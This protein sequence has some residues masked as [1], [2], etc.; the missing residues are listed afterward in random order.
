MLFRSLLALSTSTV[1]TSSI[2]LLLAIGVRP[3]AVQLVP[4]VVQDQHRVELVGRDIVQADVYTEVE[5]RA[6]VQSA[7]D[8]QSGFTGLRGV[9]FVL[10]AVVAT[11]TLRRVRTEAGIAQFLAPKGPMDEVAKGGLLRPLPR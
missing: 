1:T 10:R 5:R 7:P 8:E 9:E 11:A 4:F 2:W 6:Q 3:L